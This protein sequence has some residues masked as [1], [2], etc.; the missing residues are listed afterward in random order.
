MERHDYDRQ[1]EKMRGQLDEMRGRVEQLFGKEYTG[2]EREMKGRARQTMAEMRGEVT[3]GR[4]FLG[5]GTVALLGVGVLALAIF[6]P[7]TFRRITDRF[8]DML[9]F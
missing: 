3:E 7:R 8:F 4:G 9:G 6:S 5:L 2:R 1:L